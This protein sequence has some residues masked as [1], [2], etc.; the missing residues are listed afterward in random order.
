MN[1]EELL[2]NYNQVQERVITAAPDPDRVNIIAVSK[3]KSIEEI[4]TL[5]AAG[6]RD[7]G[8]NYIQELEEKAKELQQK[9]ITDI[10][11][12]FLGKL[13]TNKIKSLLSHVY[14]VHSMAPID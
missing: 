13:Q 8:E 14:Q 5:Y 11:W 6:Q 9:G 10:R 2:N 12:H 3:K 7:F 4:E 1:K